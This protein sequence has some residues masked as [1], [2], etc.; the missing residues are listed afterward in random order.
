MG[1]DQR[2]APQMEQVENLQTNSLLS[3]E[4]ARGRLE[5]IILQLF[6]HD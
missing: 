3:M 4:N 1:A 2:G 6:Q 5:F